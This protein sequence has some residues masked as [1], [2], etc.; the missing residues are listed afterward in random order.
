M[1]I[2][3]IFFWLIIFSLGAL[4]SCK[5]QSNQNNSALTNEKIETNRKVFKR[6]FNELTE[7]GYEALLSKTGES[8]NPK[9]FILWYTNET[10]E[11]MAQDR[12]RI[13]GAFPSSRIVN[14]CGCK[15][16]QI[17]LWSVP[18]LD[19][20]EQ[21]DT[22]K[23]K[24]AQT[25]GVEEDEL[26]EDIFITP[27]IQLGSLG[28]LAS[29]GRLPK[30]TPLPPNMKAGTITIAMLDTGVDYT[31]GTGGNR[32]LPI[33][34]NP[35][36]PVID[37]KDGANDPFCIVDDVIGYDFVNDDNNPMDDHS[38]GTHLSG[39]IA[40]ELKTH[41]S[42]INYR[43]LPVK[44][45]DENGVGTSFHAACGVVYAALKKADLINASWGYYG[46]TDNL[47]RAAFEFAQ[48]RQV[49]TVN[50]TGNEQV[51]LGFV[52]HIPTSFAF[53]RKRLLPSIAYLSA[54]DQA[55]K[56]Y[57]N[58]NFR[59]Q[60]VYSKNGGMVG[61]PGENIVSLVPNHLKK[62]QSQLERK[63][64]TSIS[65]AFFTAWA[66]SYIDI[67]PRHKPG[68]VRRNLYEIFRKDAPKSFGDPYK[69]GKRYPFHKIITWIPLSKAKIQSVDPKA[70]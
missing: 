4:P 42:G 53:Q 51:D 54:L 61:T 1:K 19:I 25:L 39:I 40:D 3:P 30:G 23:S 37:G 52:K 24:M 58:S 15:E 10:S 31:Y 8:V 22:G 26:E 38:H 65:A 34:R 16:F 13:K 57:R 60:G 27:D 20:N 17:N 12:N 55:N 14:S 67:Y 70:K 59:T 46:T 5:A 69:E 9:H 11:R 36:D 32:T 21:G 66:A 18:G 63:S 28:R 64:G 44:I 35:L 62:Y 41:A 48:S 43:I 47:L 56:L 50:S 33:W 68:R 2:T 49:M 7:Q 29:G 45:M 6:K